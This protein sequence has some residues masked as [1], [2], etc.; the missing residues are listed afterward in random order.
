[1]NNISIVIPVFNGS[2]ALKE[3][4]LSI[5]NTLSTFCSEFEI[6]LVDDYSLDNSWEE[7]QSLCMLSPHIKGVKLS[8][9]FGQ[10]NAVFCGL[11][12]AKY[13]YIVTMDDDLQHNPEDIKLLFDKIKEGYSVVYG[14]SKQIYAYKYRKLGSK[15]TNTLFNII[16]KKPKNVNISSFR[17]MD[18][19]IVDKIIS[20]S[21]NYVYISAQ[22]FRFTKN[23][24]S[25]PIRTFKRK[26]GDSNYTFSK[27]LTI[28]LKIYIY[29]SKN[30]LMRVFAKSQDIYTV[31]EVISTTQNEVIK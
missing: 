31:E 16:I 17:I 13:D 9:N 2:N 10:Q 8:K 29:Y 6:I 5:N 23:V 22:T 3:L 1:M 26:Y 20:N 11:N 14:Y 28:F 18:K 27:L 4:C 21:K 15:L 7:I 30:P 19:K 24:T 25:I 12:Y